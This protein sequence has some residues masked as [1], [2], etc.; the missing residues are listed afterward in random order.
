MHVRHTFYS[1]SS[2]LEGKPNVEDLVVFFTEGW[3]LGY[4]MCIS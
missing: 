4:G 3:R 2:E 1:R